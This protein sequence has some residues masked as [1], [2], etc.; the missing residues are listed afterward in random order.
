MAAPSLSERI[1]QSFVAWE[2]RGRGWQL[3]PYPV[4]LEPPFRPFLLLPGKEAAIEHV[5]DGRHPTFFS[6]LAERAIAAFSEPSPTAPREEFEEQGPFPSL[7]RDGI[8]TRRLLLP[9]DLKIHR[10]IQAQLLI[11]L[12]AG[13][14]PVSF[15]LIGRSGTV[16][17][18]VA[19]SSLDEEH[20]F[21]TIADHLPDVTVLADEDALCTEDGLHSLAVDF[22]YEDEFFLPILGIRAFTLDAYV[23]L[24]SALSRTRNGE[25]LCFQVLFERTRNPWREAIMGAV[26]A[27]D[28]APLFS[29]APDFVPAAREKTAAPLFACSIRLC[30][31]SDSHE[32]LL[33]L[34]RGTKAF[35]EQ[36]T[37][38]GGNSLIPLSNDE[39]QHVDHTAAILERESFRTGMVVSLD[40]LLGLVHLPDSS[41][42]HEGFVRVAERA[43]ALPANAK[44]HELVIGTND[45]RGTQT[46]A[47]LASSDRLQHV[48]IA[49]A[50]GTGKSTLLVN[51]IRQ[52]M[53]RGHGLAVLDPHGDL[54]DEVLG[55]VP[56]SRSDDVVLFDPADEAWPVGF[57][58]LVADTALER[59][60]LAS[61][62][63]GVFQRFSTS[64]GDSMSTVLSN[65]ILAVL[66]HPQGGTLLH[67]RRFLIE[68]G[69]RKSFLA[70]VK[71]EEVLF[72][73]NKEWPL[74]GSRS[75]GPIL[76]RLNT[77][78]RP[79]LL[80]HIVGQR[81]PKLQLS[82][83]IGDRRIFVAKLS[84]GL[85]GNENAYVLGAL[86]L[87]KF[88]Q[89]AL[90][91]QQIAQ[92]QRAPFWLYLDEAEHFVTPSLASLLTQARKYGVGLTMAFQMLSQLRTVPQ[93]ESAVLGNAH[94]WHLLERVVYPSEEDVVGSEAAKPI[95]ENY[96]TSDVCLDLSHKGQHITIGR[97]TFREAQRVMADKVV[98]RRDR[99]ELRA[100]LAFKF[101]D[102]CR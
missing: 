76:T 38:P 87:G 98:C 62:L 32:R 27:P 24:I 42:R 60:L 57:N 44:E 43:K 77:F 58:V 10:D 71:D 97:R 20:V 2:L 25:T 19:C 54:A 14:H 31:W 101:F 91:R 89:V 15:E 95:T 94:I 85:I 39:Y 7:P 17:L 88:L 8:A 33:D 34:A 80:R 96:I 9:S 90:S 75:I 16:T 53:E 68:D 63:V 56:A 1:S 35:I 13:H 23:P 41:V 79:K 6:K 64:W 70:A 74:I 93:V 36:Y 66:E 5:D 40:E 82:A 67:L 45:Y 100:F 61:D 69:Y 51:M 99:N 28:G 55:L 73:W 3:A 4:W 11:A 18:Q 72:F 81:A 65:A 29:D 37:R 26:V 84:Q 30:A 21:T 22:G 48:M 50:S 46:T 12:G 52:D 102:E 47:T 59:T 86:L 92:T 49:G 78:L 83:V